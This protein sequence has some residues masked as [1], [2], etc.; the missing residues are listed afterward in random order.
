MHCGMDGVQ[1]DGRN[2]VEPGLLK[3]KRH[4]AGTGE[5][6][7]CCGSAIHLSSR[8]HRSYHA[9]SRASSTCTARLPELTTLVALVLAFVCCPVAYSPRSSVAS[10]R[11][12]ISEGDRSSTGG[13]ARSNRKRKSLS[14][15]RR[16]P[17]PVYRANRL[18]EARTYSPCDAPFGGHPSQ[19]KCPWF[20]H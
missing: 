10:I 13:H 19:R 20:R 18:G 7:Y 4:A 5:K 3:S 2:D 12:F 6:V 14:G 9:A 8:S 15:E 17:S 11:V 16:K 1:L